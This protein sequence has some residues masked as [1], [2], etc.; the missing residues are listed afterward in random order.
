MPYFQLKLQ[1]TVTSVPTIGFN[2]ETLDIAPGLEMTVWDIGG[3][4][5]I[6]PLW[7]HYYQNL[8]G[9]IWIVDSQDDQRFDESFNEFQNVLNDDNLPCGDLP[10]L[11][12]ANKQDLPG[13]ANSEKVT[14]TFSYF[15]NL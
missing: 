2:V 15:T 10:I 4:D 8:D 12:Y 1:E 6:R 5:V 9:I 14:K 7:R 11:I 13:A 3:Q